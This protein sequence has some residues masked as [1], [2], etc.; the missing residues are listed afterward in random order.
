MNYYIFEIWW[1]FCCQIVCEDWHGR[2]R[3]WFYLFTIKIIIIISM[4][5]LMLYWSKILNVKFLKIFTFRIL[6]KS[7][8]LISNKS[9]REGYEPLTS[10]FY[11]KCHLK[12]CLYVLWLKFF[13]IFK[14]AKI[15]HWWTYSASYFHL[16]L[17]HL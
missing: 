8:S 11:E 3:G 4:I 5:F 9:H 1:F 2:E 17:F 14:T 16:L 13:S 15:A 12:N 7:F 6:L 10:N